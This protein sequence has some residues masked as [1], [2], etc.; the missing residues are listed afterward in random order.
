VRVRSRRVAPQ[1]A[2]ASALISVAIALGIGACLAGQGVCFAT[3]TEGVARLGDAQRQ[4]RLDDELRK[5]LWT[6]LLI[7]D[8]VGYIP[9]DPPPT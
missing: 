4:G 1:T 6:P 7:V 2:S 9:F 3:A 5:P 8:E